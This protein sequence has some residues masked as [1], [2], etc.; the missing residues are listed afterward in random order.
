MTEVILGLIAAGALLLTVSG[1]LAG[2]DLA[3]DGP[4]YDTLQGKAIIA[5]AATGL[6][7]C[8]LGLL[9]LVLTLV[10]TGEVPQ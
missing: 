3:H 1:A 9:T 6:S 4:H 10:T 5:L 7:L 2:H 8:G